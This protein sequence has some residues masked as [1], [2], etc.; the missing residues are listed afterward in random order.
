[1]NS[2]W[3]L[4]SMDRTHLCERCNLGSIPRGPMFIKKNSM[5]IRK[6][7]SPYNY[8]S[9][10]IILCI[11]LL[12]GIGQFAHKNNNIV[13]DTNNYIQAPEGI[14]EW[15]EIQTTGTIQPDNN[16]P[17]Y[18]HSI[19]LEDW[20]KIWLKS[21]TINLNIFSGI[22]NVIWTVSSIQKWLPI[23]NVEYVRDMARKYIV[24]NNVY[25][26]IPE[27]IIINLD[28][29]WTIYSF[30]E[31]WNIYIISD[32]IPVITIRTFSCDSENPST[33]CE[34]YRNNALRQQSDSFIS[35]RWVSFYKIDDGKRIAFNEI[36]LGYII[37]WDD[38]ENIIDFSSTI[39]PINSAY[40]IRQYKNEIFSNC[41][42]IEQINT[43]SIQ[44]NG[45]MLDI[46]VQWIDNQ[47]SNVWCNISIDLR[48]RKW[49]TNV[50]IF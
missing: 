15:K 50:S 36:K 49:I 11:I 27:Q 28:N 34:W 45:D 42:E 44:K 10:I 35:D 24:E 13:L 26:Y 6:I 5:T 23:I 32:N 31:T 18:T 12:I 38:D 16:F 19:I 21:S 7:R 37:E 8:M 9:K 48:D 40:I 47:R 41:D 46:T 17:L 29:L 1:M 33:D 14:Q 2:I 22:F 43:A 25:T 30:S 20:S 3:A 39:Q 4:R